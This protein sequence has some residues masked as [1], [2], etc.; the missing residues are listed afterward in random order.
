MRVVIIFLLVLVTL[1]ALAITQE[2]LLTELNLILKSY[3]DETASLRAHSHKLETQV[4][5]LSSQSVDLNEQIADLK[6]SYS[7]FKQRASNE[8]FWLKIGFFTT[9]TLL[10]ADIVIHLLIT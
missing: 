4:E 1:P 5:M 9:A 6:T 10:V 3:E 7:E 2:E 8:A